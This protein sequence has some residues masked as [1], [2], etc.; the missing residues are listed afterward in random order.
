MKMLFNDLETG[1]KMFS[2]VYWKLKSVFERYLQETDGT[3][4]KNYEGN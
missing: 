4:T 3:L 2:Y 1:F